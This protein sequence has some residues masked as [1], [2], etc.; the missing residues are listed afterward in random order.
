MY[1]YRVVKIKQT[2]ELEIY[3]TFYIVENYDSWRNRMSRSFGKASRR[4]DAWR[5]TDKKKKVTKNITIHLT[6]PPC[7]TRD[8]RYIIYKVG[9]ILLSV[10]WPDRCAAAGRITRRP[11]GHGMTTRRR[12][13]VLAVGKHNIWSLA[14]IITTR[15]H[16]SR[17]VSRRRVAVEALRARATATAGHSVRVWSLAR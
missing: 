3:L 17:R 2:V 16:Y 5:G 11:H 7:F 6:P 9:I 12:P 14:T 4:A 13:G 15:T 1:W 8:D 10:S